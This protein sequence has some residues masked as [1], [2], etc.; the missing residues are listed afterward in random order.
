MAPQLPIWLQYAQTIGVLAIAFVG[1]FIAWQQVEIAR[2]KLRHDAYDRRFKLY[3]AAGKF[4]AQIIKSAKIDGDDVRE[5]REGIGEA[6]FLLDE[7]TA[8]FLISIADRAQFAMVNQEEMDGMPSGPERSALARKKG[9]TI[10]WMFQ[11]FP[12]LTSKFRPYLQLP[13]PIWPRVKKLILRWR[14]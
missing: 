1:A 13:Q 11:Q 2:E 6:V 9:E 14:H 5:Y 12:I 8:A 4:L 10:Q 3:D 7:E